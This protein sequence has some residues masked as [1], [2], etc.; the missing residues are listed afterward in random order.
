MAWD[1]VMVE[2]ASLAQ[3]TGKGMDSGSGVIFQ[4]V[5]S[6]LYKNYTTV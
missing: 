5:N 3:M 2:I 6:L 1:D 4:F